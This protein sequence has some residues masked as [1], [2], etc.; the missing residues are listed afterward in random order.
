MCIRDSA[1][2]ALRTLARWTSAVIGSPRL[3]RAFPPSATTILI[4]GSQRG[5]EHSLDPVSYTHLDVYKR[6]PEYLLDPGTHAMYGLVQWLK[7]ISVDSEICSIGSANI[8]IRS[9]SVN[10]ELNAVLYSRR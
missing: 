4:S 5:N 7:T 6:Q 10:Y 9:F 8:E 2:A 3:R 1:S